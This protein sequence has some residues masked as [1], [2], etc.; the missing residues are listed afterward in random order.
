M[1]D[2]SPVKPFVEV[3]GLALSRGGREVLRGLDLDVR[4]GEIFGLLGPNG[5]GK[6]SAFQ[7]LAGLLVADGGTVVL[8]GREL[9]PGH[10]DL[11]ARTGV[12]FQSPA[13]DERLTARANLSLAGRLQGLTGERLA[14]RVS[15]M[16]SFARL[17]GRDREPVKQLSGGM[18]RRLEI[19]RA[20]VHEPDLLLMDEPTTGLDEVSYQRFWKSVRGL[21]EGG[22]SVLLTTHR[23]EEA[24]LC[25]RLAFLF[26]GK[27][28][29]CDTPDNLR[30][31]VG[32]DVLELTVED[33]EAVARGLKE[34]MGLPAEVAVGLVRV[35]SERGHELV[36]R[37][38]EALPEGSLESVSVRRPGLGDV[39]LSLTGRGLLEDEA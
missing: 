23:A 24:E 36:P 26:G 29:A 10:R 1:P 32:G 15:A 3:N 9:P 2:E 31:R 34:E 33:P 37:V 14:E 30:R 18:R 6:S 21:A 12:V 25:G 4:R 8:D 7:A 38:V 16:V 11:R 35:V 39:F 20:F 22:V 5:A 28:V 19:A 17:E 13:L 27:I